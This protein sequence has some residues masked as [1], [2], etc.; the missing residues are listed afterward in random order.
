[1]KNN[2]FRK[3]L[4]CGIIIL[5]V[6]A[7]VIPMISG[8]MNNGYVNA[9]WKFDECS[10]STVGDYSGNGN[11]GTIYGATWVSGYSGCAL[12]FDGVDDYV[13]FDDYAKYW[14][15]FNNTDD[16]IFSF[17]F[18]S[19]STDRGVIYS[20]CRGDAYGLQ[21]GVNIA[22]AANGSVEFQVW[23][24]GCGILMWSDEGYNDGSWHYVEIYYN[25]NAETR[26]QNA[27][28]TI[29][30]DDTYQGIFLYPVC[31]FYD[32]K[33]KYAQM[34]RDSNE[35]DDYFD[36][37][38]D[39]F[40]IIEYGGGNQQS[41]PNIDGPVSGVPGVEYHY[42]FITDDPEGDDLLEIEIDWGNGDIWT[43]EGPFASGEEVV[44]GYTWAEE[45]TYN[46]IARS[47]DFWR[48][49]E[50]SDYPHVVKI[51]NDAPGAPTISGPNNGDAG[52]SYDYAFRAFDPDGDNVRYIID[53]GDTTSDTT[54]FV[55][56]GT[57]KTVSHTWSTGGN[58]TIKAKAEDSFGNI[59]PETTKTVTMPRD[60]VLQ[61]T[62][63]SKLLEWFPNAFPILQLILKLAL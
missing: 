32:D 22:L 41:P 51:G 13:N 8:S 3:S 1:M 10:G 59:G 12:E 35:S 34:G 36:G 19:T 7:A 20:T 61:N 27:T 55:A 47:K 5:F 18:K 57:S 58:F 28:G 39:E 23:M 49:S 16:M 30:V 52:K 26:R 60:K 6:G 29:Y 38:I 31:S 44:V 33:F 15:G 11:I 14:L 50:W 37:V 21:P 40:K 56:S 43:V 48:H 63:F 45:G 24:L 17:Y 54:E 53:W 4:V 62:L 46:I 2:L 9:Y 25:G 42:T